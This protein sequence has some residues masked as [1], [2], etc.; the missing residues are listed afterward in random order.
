[1]L[2]INVKQKSLVV[3]NEMRFDDLVV[4]R[5]RRRA[6]VGFVNRLQESMADWLPAWDASLRPSM[7]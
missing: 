5:D 6:L 4:V 1:M 7:F 2:R 3:H